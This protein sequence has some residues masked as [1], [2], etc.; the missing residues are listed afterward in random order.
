MIPVSLWF[1]VLDTHRVAPGVAAALAKASPPQHAVDGLWSWSHMS[2][3]AAERTAT[4][5]RDHGVGR[6][7]GVAGTA[8]GLPP[9]DPVGPEPLGAGLELVWVQGRATV[10]RVV[11][12]APRGPG[13]PP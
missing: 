10:R 3:T 1:L 6:D 9:L 12:R 5:L 7:A 13:D 8:D 2:A 11:D 4:A